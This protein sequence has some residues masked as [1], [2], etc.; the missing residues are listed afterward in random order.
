METRFQ[1]GQTVQ[2]PRPGWAGTVV[3]IDIFAKRYLLDF[4]PGAPAGY[5]WYKVPEDVLPYPGALA[6]NWF[7]ED[8][9]AEDKG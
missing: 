9:L 7:H 6:G 1:V 3:M 8:E 4:H 5:V 2:T